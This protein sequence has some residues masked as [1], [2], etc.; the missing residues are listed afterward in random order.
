M[1]P[2]YDKI[3]SEN[4]INHLKVAPLFMLAFGYWM[5][6][7]HT[8][9]SNDDIQPVKFAGDTPVTNHSLHD[10]FNSEGWAAPAWPLLVFS[11]FFIIVLV[12]GTWMEDLFNKVFSAFNFENEEEIEEI[13]DS[14]WDSLDDNDRDW[15]T[16]EEH[17][18]RYE[19][20]RPDSTQVVIDAVEIQK[21]VQ[22]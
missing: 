18:F 1:P 11:L 4:V 6:S 22:C 10:L 17:Y 9:L 19:L 7:S 21:G 13:L 5:L 15:S 14:Y 20:K 16:Q 12:C 3:L 2:Q 8:L